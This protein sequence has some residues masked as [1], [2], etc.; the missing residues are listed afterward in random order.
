MLARALRSEAGR[1]KLDHGAPVLLQMA[2]LAEEID[3]LHRTLA[4]T[5]EEYAAVRRRPP[6]PDIM[7]IA[8]GDLV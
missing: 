6:Q 1:L 7:A 8:F 3:S 2:Q 5:S 4:E